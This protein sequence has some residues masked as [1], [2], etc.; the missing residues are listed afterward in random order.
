MVLFS[1][2]VEPEPDVG[3]M[4]D[5]RLLSLLPSLASVPAAVVGAVGVT[6]RENRLTSARTGCGLKSDMGR[7]LPEPAVASADGSP[8]EPKSSASGA[9]GCS[10]GTSGAMSASASACAPTS[11]TSVEHVESGDSGRSSVSVK[12]NWKETRRG[13]GAGGGSRSNPPST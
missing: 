10:G 2:L 3:S 13:L 6:G 4:N 7:V 9:G 11:V 1:F 5:F 8:T 12:G